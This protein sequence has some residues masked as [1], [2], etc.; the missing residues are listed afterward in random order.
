L[1]LVV[2]LR[3]LGIRQLVLQE[4]PELR[5]V[6]QQ[7]VQVFRQREPQRVPGLPRLELAM[8]P[9]SQQLVQVQILRQQACLRQRQEQ[10]QLSLLA[11][12]WQQLS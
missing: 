6:P 8:E 2:H 11:P 1:G 9:A 7:Q 12:F 10:R 4:V 5:L 3:S